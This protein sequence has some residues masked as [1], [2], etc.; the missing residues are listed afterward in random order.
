MKNGNLVI[1]VFN[2]DDF[3]LEGMEEVQ[4][5]SN[6]IQMRLKSPFKGSDNILLESK[7]VEGAPGI[8]MRLTKENKNWNPSGPRDQSNKKFFTLAKIELKTVGSGLVKGQ[9]S[10]RDD[11]IIRVSFMPK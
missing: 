4:V 1:E 2:A 11:R 8:G 5:N 10:M 7:D 9:Q 6:L 3:N